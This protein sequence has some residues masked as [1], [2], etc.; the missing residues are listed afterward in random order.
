MDVLFVSMLFL[1]SRPFF[2]GNLPQVVRSA[3]YLCGWMRACSPSLWAVMGGPGSKLLEQDCMS[4]I[5]MMEV[6]MAFIFTVEI[7]TPA[8]NLIVCMVYWQ[9]M[10]VRYIISSQTDQHISNAFGSVRAKTDE[11]IVM[12]AR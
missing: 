7:F 1:S 3:V 6:V 9:L 4:L 11:W 10:R 2:F 8:R 12:S 5:A